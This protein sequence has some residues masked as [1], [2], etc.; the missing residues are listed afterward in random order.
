MFFLWKEKQTN[1]AYKIKGRI[2]YKIVF[3]PAL[4]CICSSSVQTTYELVFS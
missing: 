1:I 2:K 4:L 3:F